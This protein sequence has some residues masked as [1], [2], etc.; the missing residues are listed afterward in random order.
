MKISLEL[1]DCLFKFFLSVSLTSFAL[2]SKLVCIWIWKLW[3]DSD[4]N[5]WFLKVL[6]SNHFTSVCLSLNFD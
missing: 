2:V 4:I 1:F 3:M 5:I 6:L